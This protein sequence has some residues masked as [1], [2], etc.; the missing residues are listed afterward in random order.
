MEVVSERGRRR[1]DHDMVLG[2]VNKRDGKTMCD[3]AAPEGFLSGEL[4]CRRLRAENGFS[5]FRTESHTES[6]LEFQW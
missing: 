6:D 2:I 5:T 4:R 1:S 3:A